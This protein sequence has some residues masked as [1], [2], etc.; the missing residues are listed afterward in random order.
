MERLVERVAK[1]GGSELV[2]LTPPPFDP[3]LRRV[4]DR[5]ALR[6]GAAYPSIEYAEQLRRFSRWS[7][8]RRGQGLA[9]IDVNQ[10]LARHLAER[11]R[12]R[13]SFYLSPDGIHPNP[14]GHWLIAQAILQSWNAPAEVSLVEIDAAGAEVLSGEVA[15]LRVEDDQL[16]FTWKSRLPMP[17]HE[18]WDP[19]SLELEKFDERFNLYRLRVLNAPAQRYSL[20]IDGEEM[21]SFGR[22]DLARGVDMNSLANSPAHRRAR[23]VLGMVA[24]RQ[25]LATRSWFRETKGG[26]SGPEAPGSA[27][28]KRLDAE[29]RQLSLPMALEV[30]LRALPEEG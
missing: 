15:D 23:E 16:S 14:T 8:A 3:Y 26:A 6:Y 19:E 2:V 7:V 5:K 10:Q 25:T 18:K 22:E 11:R 9:V 27:E 13:V 1:L 12:E 21:G 17:R 24:E 4:W 29:I 30:R 28:L 20:L